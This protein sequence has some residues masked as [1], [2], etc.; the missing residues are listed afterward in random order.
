M[1]RFQEWSEQGVVDEIRVAGKRRDV[2]AHRS[3]HGPHVTLLHGFP[4]SSSEWI[5]VAEGIGRQHSLLA[6]DLLGYG[7][8]TKQLEASPTVVMQADMI[9]AL[10]QHYGVDSTSLVGYDVGGMVIMELLARRSEGRL[11][12]SV[13]DVVLL[14]SPLY[15]DT[16]RPRAVTRMMAGGP[17]APLARRLLNER[18]LT[19]SWSATFS[20]EHPLD[21]ETA[22]EHWEALVAGGKPARIG[23]LLGFVRE[24]QRQGSRWDNALATQPLQLIWGRRDIVSGADVESV[25]ERLPNARATVLGDLGHAPHIED[26]A[27]VAP[28]LGAALSG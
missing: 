1:T 12:V 22:H 3:G 6:P 8:S 19:A 13:D 5:D 4:A 14:N 17:L 15:S 7:R 27:R 2:F 21:P 23:S 28:I 20:D 16:Y 10:W 11:P 18:T 26:P 9:V 25:G 24:R